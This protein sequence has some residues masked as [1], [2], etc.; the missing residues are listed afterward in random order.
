MEH[1]RLLAGS[2]TR[3]CASEPTHAP[4]ATGGG[5]ASR[6]GIDQRAEEG[7]STRL[8]VRRSAG[9]SERRR[10]RFRRADR[11]S[12]RRPRSGGRRRRDRPRRSRVSTATRSRSSSTARPAPRQRCPAIL[13]LHGGGMA[14]GGADRRSV[15]AMARRT[16][17]RR[18]GGD[19]GRVPQLGRA[20][21][22]RTRSP[23]G[24]TTAPRR[25]MWMASNRDRLGVSTIVVSGE[26]GGGNLTLATAIRAKR[27]GD[28][29][30]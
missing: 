7:R 24:S 1:S 27:D 5:D 21:S 23:P 10:T 4:T 2:A 28:H 14:I 16:G 25:C 30:C 12:L 11:P 22:G 13:H 18:R 6:S 8:A 15:R 9:L 26:S 29:R 3:R 17:R 20:R 19:R